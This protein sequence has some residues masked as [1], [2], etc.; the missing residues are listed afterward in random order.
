MTMTSSLEALARLV[1]LPTLCAAWTFSGAAQTVLVEAAAAAGLDAAREGA[2]PPE[3]LGVQ[4]CNTTCQTRYTDCMDRCDGVPACQA[5]CRR[6]VDDCVHVCTVPPT[7]S[8]AP[9]SSAAPAPSA[10]PS[11][12]APTPKKSKPKG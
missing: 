12:K 3:R 4:T 1:V 10:A 5:E 7:G 9:P 11:G 8:A 6:T 2:S